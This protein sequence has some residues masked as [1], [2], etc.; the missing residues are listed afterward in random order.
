MVPKELYT[1]DCGS[2]V[3][4]E[5]D[6]DDTGGHVEFEHMTASLQKVENDT[7]LPSATLLKEQLPLGKALFHFSRVQV[8]D[9]VQYRCVIIFGST[10]DCKH[11]ILKV[12]GELFQRQE[13]MQAS[14]TQDL[15]WAEAKA[16]RI[17]IKR[18][19]YFKEEKNACSELFF[20]SSI[21]QL[22]YG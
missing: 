1:V 22:T 18:P 16:G 7:S 6:F 14:P 21:K 9:A 2:N 5:C 12:K 11:L 13:S 20:T 4:L 10:W 15:M 19:S 3:T 17:I 8:R